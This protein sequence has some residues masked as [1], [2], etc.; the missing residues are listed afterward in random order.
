MS[1]SAVG[2]KNIKSFYQKLDLTIEPL[3]FLIGTN[4]S[5]KS[6]VFNT[7]NIIKSSL[8]LDGRN[9]I[10][11]IDFIKTEYSTGNLRQRYGEIESFLPN[12][13]IDDNVIEISFK[14]FSTAI[15][16]TLTILFKINIDKDKRHGLLHSLEVISEDN[17]L[18]QI[19][20]NYSTL[21]VNG[22][23]HQVLNSSTIKVNFK[24]YFDYFFNSLKQYNSL[25][26][27][28]LNKKS[29]INQL[30]ENLINEKIKKITIE[31]EKLNYQ[32]KKY[33]EILFEK[34]KIE[35]HR[36]SELLFDFKEKIFFS[37]YK[38]KKEDIKYLLSFLRYNK[39]NLEYDPRLLFVKYLM[40]FIK[41]SYFFLYSNNFKS[42]SDTDKIEK[43]LFE[44]ILLNDD[45]LIEI[46]N[47]F[48]AIN[49]EIEKIYKLTDF[50]FENFE[51][52][53]ETLVH[54]IKK[55]ELFSEI[56]DYF[57]M[58]DLE[59]FD[60]TEFDKGISIEQSSICEQLNNAKNINFKENEKD[61][62]QIN[63][64][65]SSDNKGFKNK[66]KS[67]FINE[68][69]LRNSDIIT[70]KESLSSRLWELLSTELEICYDKI[71]NLRS[72]LYI[73]FEYTRAF[74]ERHDDEKSFSRFI[75]N[76]FIDK[77]FLFGLET[78]MIASRFNS[79]TEHNFF[80][81]K[82][83]ILLFINEN[84]L[85]DI[86]LKRIDSDELG[87]SDDEL[88]SLSFNE[89]HILWDKLLYFISIP[90]GKRNN[91]IF[92]QIKN[93]S[94]E[95]HNFIRKKL[96]NFVFV[97]NFRTL[98]QRNIYDLPHEFSLFQKINFSSIREV[99]L[100]R[101]NTLLSYLELNAQLDIEREDRLGVTNFYLLSNGKKNNLSVEGQGLSQFIIL[102]LHIVY[103]SL[104]VKD[105][106][107]YSSKSSDKI[108][109][110]EEPEIS[111]HPAFQSK[112]A[113]LFIYCYKEFGIFLVI[114]T[115]SEYLIRKMQL[116]V[117]K[118]AIDSDKVLI[119]YF[120]PTTSSAVAE[121]KYEIEINKSGLLSK[122][123]GEGFFD[124]SNNLILDLFFLNLNNNN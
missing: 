11:M 118:N 114:E 124:I 8:E 47:Y 27:F 45:E 33:I 97:P 24:D 10:N 26:R 59:I 74:F 88:L 7:I 35:R 51:G 1:F 29:D 78:Y 17:I 82:Y 68:L 122:P 56:T 46:K 90:F 105:N 75:N 30:V 108:V 85:H 62:F 58:N 53:S 57:K 94:E 104:D 107:I 28:L 38:C 69:E 12:S 34:L 18:I 89:Q 40:A 91:F 110:I 2:I 6:T 22:I 71:D 5:G 9:K 84:N 102:I 70:L 113:D 111:L 37:D 95:I 15:L 49:N 81:F 121:R 76:F 43:L 119:H 87:Y 31:E 73:A 23:G 117:K 41:D 79:V 60:F 19:I 101:V 4:N 52:I 100:A 42:S 123:F 65:F 14:Y 116:L 3:T 36:T 16:K 63:K 92:S 103:A 83:L 120:N 67:W 77:S 98:N 25:I 32:F 50:S 80:I 20:P 64:L 99:Y 54:L 96:D 21:N 109:F 72:G 13:Q 66:I 44:N 115:H 112:L 61:I 93:E 86:L 48:T 39:N 106:I 55:N